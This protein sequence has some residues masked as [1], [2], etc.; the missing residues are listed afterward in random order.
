LEK[1]RKERD[2]GKV[3]ASLERLE[4]VAQT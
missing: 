2:D 4:Q 1:L 3:K